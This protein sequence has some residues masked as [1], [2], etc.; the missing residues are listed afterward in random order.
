[1]EDKEKKEVSFLPFHAINEFMVDEYRLEVIRLVLG[2]MDSMTEET[3]ARIDR[4]IKHAVKVPGFRNSLKAPI[5]L[6]VKPTVEA[7]KKSPGLVAAMLAGWTELHPELR[8]Q[9]YDLLVA[10][11]WEILPIDADRTRLPGFIT[12]WPK[13]D[14]YDALYQGYMD[15]HPEA[16]AEKNDVSLMVVWLGNRLPYQFIEPVAEEKPVESQEDS[17]PS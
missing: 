4:N 11:K 7:F 15:A 10:R 3:R 17:Q 5:P 9:V 12:N 13:A 14:D 2:S 6:K 16:Q 8:Q 1:M